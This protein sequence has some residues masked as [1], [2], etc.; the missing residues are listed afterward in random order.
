MKKRYAA[1]GIHSLKKRLSLMLCLSL[2][3][4]SLIPALAED[5]GADAELPEWT[6]L[7]YM[8]GS[9]LESQHGMASF[10]LH[11]IMSSEQPSKTVQ[12][13][14]ETGQWQVE[15]RPVQVNVL[16]EVGG[17]SAW[18][19][20]PDEDGVTWPLEVAS[21]RLQRFELSHEPNDDGIYPLELV[22]EQP[23]ASM[24]DPTTLTDFILWGTQRHPAKKTALVL[25][26]HGGGSSTGLLYDELYNDDVMYLY[27]LGDALAAA[28]QYFEMMVLD[29]CLMCSLETGVILEPYT[30]WMV[31]SEDVVAG[32][33]SA[34]RE[35]LHGMFL[36][37]KVDGKRISDYLCTKTLEKYGEMDDLKTQEQLTWSSIR[38]DKIEPVAKAFDELADYLTFWYEHEPQNLSKLLKIISKADQYGTGREGMRDLGGFLFLDE[39][40]SVVDLDL[41]NE[42]ANALFDAIFCSMN[43]DLRT[44]SYGLSYCYP[45]GMAP[46]QLDSY[47]KNC[48]SAPYLAY[49]DAVIPDWHAP[50]WIYEQTRRLTP[51]EQIDYYQNLGELVVEDGIP[52][53]RGNYATDPICSCD[54]EIYMEDEDTGELILLERDEANL[55]NLDGGGYVYTMDG[56]W[57]WFAIDGQLCC[58]EYAGVYE[59]SKYYLTGPDVFLYHIPIQLGSDTR[60]LLMGYWTEVDEQTGEETSKSEIYGLADTFNSDKNVPERS[61]LKLSDIQG[62]EYELLYPIYVEGAPADETHYIR[63]DSLTMY[64]SLDFGE[65]PLPAGEYYCAYVMRDC[66]RRVHRSDMVKMTWDGGKLTVAE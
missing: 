40:E 60:E 17:A 44:A 34:F 5:G 59:R 46:E 50:D 15:T 49:L 52:K 33:G 8:C 10:N 61:V 24:T 54:Y 42:L 6:V 13:D 45:I 32:H 29:A 38:L 35:W 12:V 66:F 2:V 20:E 4:A 64:K 48:K 22:D 30:K 23:I 58:A 25:W 18:H 31:G 9:D 28:G 55:E 16:V 47:A 14:W 39:I 11:E 36:N 53:I 1:E 26:G 65:I 7:I 21:D 63:G 57:K 41:R 62:Q 43:G 27:E 37:P 56:P 51:V 19:N 3:L